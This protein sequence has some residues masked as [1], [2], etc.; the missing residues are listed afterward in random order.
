M[1]THFVGFR[2]DEYERAKKVFGPPDFVHMIHDRRMYGDVGEND[3]IVF[4]PKGEEQVSA[5][6]WQ[7]HENW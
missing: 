5:Y 2:G 6:V 3:V 7:D 1:S 4:G